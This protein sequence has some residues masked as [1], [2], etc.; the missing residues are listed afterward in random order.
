MEDLELSDS[1]AYDLSDGDALEEA[2]IRLYIL[3]N[4]SA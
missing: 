2:V 1:D 3:Q 4:L